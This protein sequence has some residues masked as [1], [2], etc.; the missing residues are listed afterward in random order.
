MTAQYVAALY[1]VH[2]EK[3]I[4]GVK[5]FRHEIVRSYP[6]QDVT[7]CEWDQIRRFRADGYFDVRVPLDGATRD[8]EHTLG[9]HGT[10]WTPQAVYLR[11]YV[12]ELKR[13]MGNRT[14]EWVPDAAAMLLGRF[15][16]THSEVDIYA[17][18]GVLAGALA[19][20]TTLGRE[21]D[22]QTYDRM[23]GFDGLRE[24]V[25]EIRRASRKSRDA[26]QMARVT[27][28]GP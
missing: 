16:K 4:Y 25:E 22:Y 26:R 12:L 20:A 2:L 1:D 6:F 9:L 10:Y 13:R 15:L 8:S 21:K 28:A 23:P 17:V 18:M 27:A 14:H 3:V 7:G 24:F 19:D 5:I 11:F